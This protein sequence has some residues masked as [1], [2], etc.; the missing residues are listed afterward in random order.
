MCDHTDLTI[1]ANHLSFELLV[2]GLDWAPRD[3]LRDRADATKQ[4]GS[5]VQVMGN[6]IL[7]NCALPC[8]KKPRRAKVRV[9]TLQGYRQKSAPD[10]NRLEGGK[11]LALLGFCDRTWLP[12]KSK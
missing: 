10:V 6:P 8:G 11:K 7:G 9:Q 4:L 2:Q 5:L 1:V 12:F 3:L